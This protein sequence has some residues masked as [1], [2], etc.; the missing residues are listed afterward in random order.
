MHDTINKTAPI[1]TA[2]EAH[3]VVSG[4]CT[5]FQQCV[6]CCATLALYSITFAL[7]Y[8]NDSVVGKH[9]RLIRS[10]D[11]ATAKALCKPVPKYKTVEREGARG[12]AHAAVRA[13][14]INY[15][16]V[17]VIYIPKCHRH[18]VRKDDWRIHPRRNCDNI[19]ALQ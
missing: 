17:R 5:F 13:A 7:M 12:N 1:Q 2:A 18:I 16:R 6:V 3:C 10:A 11:N 14:T 8:F 9:T 4:N 15:Y 19:I